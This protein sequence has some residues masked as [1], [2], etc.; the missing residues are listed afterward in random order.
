M[1]K[2]NRVNRLRT[3]ILSNDIANIGKFNMIERKV[4]L[5]A[6]RKRL[7]FEELRDINEERLIDS[8]PISL[9]YFEI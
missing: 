6:D 2:L 9:N 4:D 7:W 5:N 8:L 1:F 3:A